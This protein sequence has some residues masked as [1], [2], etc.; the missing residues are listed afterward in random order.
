METTKTIQTVETLLRPVVEDL[1]YEFVDLQLKTDHGRRVLR[2]LVDRPGGI[3]LGE[4]A[5]LSREVNPHL[6]VADPIRGRYVLEVSSPGIQRPL[7]RVADFERFR[8]ERVVVRTTETVEGRKTFRGINLGLD[9]HGDLALED[10]ETRRCYAIP[11]TRVVEARL[12]PE[13]RF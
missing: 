10:A 13:I 5:S 9:D 1:G 8:G 11:L 7:K 12:D 3:T 2:L 6:E 4:C